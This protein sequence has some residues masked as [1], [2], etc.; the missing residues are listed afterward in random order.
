MNGTCAPHG[1]LFLDHFTCDEV[2]GPSST[3]R[4]DEHASTKVSAPDPARLDDPDLAWITAELAACSCVCCHN[5]TG[6]GAYRWSYEF[7]PTFID[8]VDDE[9]LLRFT[10]PPPPHAPKIPPEENNGFA[11]GEFG[12]PSTDKQR[13]EAFI[14]RELARRGLAP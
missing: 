2:E 5:D 6:I 13:F 9:V 1:E 7:E 4:S 8:S 10:D 11:R 14:D 3:D 12:F